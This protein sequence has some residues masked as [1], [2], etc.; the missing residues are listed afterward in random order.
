MVTQRFQTAFELPA[1]RVSSKRASARHKAT[2]VGNRE[3]WPRPQ[4]PPPVRYYHTARLHRSLGDLPPE[5]AKPPDNMGTLGPDDVEC[6][7][8]LGGLFKHYERKA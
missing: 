5:M 8:W 2:T 7:E 4:L 1:R 6:H 3:I